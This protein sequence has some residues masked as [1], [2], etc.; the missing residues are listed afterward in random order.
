MWRWLVWSAA[1][2]LLG[3]FASSALVAFDL[4]P[5]VVSTYR[6]VGG[7]GGQGGLVVAGDHLY[8][9]DGTNGLQVLDIRDPANLKRIG[10]HATINAALAVKV[11]G[12]RAYVATG[13]G[14]LLMFDVS[15]PAEPRLIGSH[16]AKSFTADVAVVGGHA[17]LADAYA[18][19]E[20]VDVSDPAHPVLVSNYGEKLS[21]GLWAYGNA[22]AVA[23]SGSTAW[24]MLSSSGFLG[25]DIQDPANPMQIT[26][27]PSP[28]F[29]DPY[30]AGT[31]ANIAITDTA[32]CYVGNFG[33]AIS[34]RKTGKAVRSQGSQ[35][36]SSAFGV[37]IAAD[38]AY[39]VG[40]GGGLYIVELGKA[41][42]PR[43]VGS[44]RIPVKP[45]DLAVAKGHA[46]VLGVEDGLTVIDV[47]PPANP[48]QR[49]SEIRGPGPGYFQDGTAFG[50]HAYTVSDAALHVFDIQDRTNPIIVGTNSSG[51]GSVV[52]VSG[53]YAYVLS[54]SAGLSILDIREPTRPQLVGTNIS[55]GG[56]AVAASGNYA[57]VFTN[58][59]LT[60]FDASDP[61]HPTQVGAY[62]LNIP[63]FFV[64]FHLVVDGGFAY[65]STFNDGFHII[66]VRDPTSPRLAGSLPDSGP[67]AVAGGY[68]YLGSYPGLKVI[69]VRDP[70]LPRIAGV[71]DYSGEPVSLA[72]HERYVYILGG[73]LRVVDVSIPSA[74]RRVGGN[75]KFNFRPFARHRVWADGESVVASQGF[76]GV[77][78]YDAFRPLEVSAVPTPDQTKV[79]L[80][81]NG[82][83]GVPFR[84]QRSPDLRSWDN[85]SNVILGDSPATLTDTGPLSGPT[86]FYR[87]VHP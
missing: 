5:Q 51:G 25:I 34:D 11:A 18:G 69:D 62:V 64:V 15:D 30:Y 6:G 9:A 57:Y 37:T 83:R 71:Y 32:F 79:G 21:P 44:F 54:S 45:T 60:V 63:H 58:A 42:S 19:L 10:G 3:L 82:P 80:T 77:T 68:A 49:S 1:F 35:I 65:V 20:V 43:L 23:V 61:T 24:L 70:T 27:L 52:A 16:A 55:G 56:H 81:V 22:S 28:H 85:L 66:D 86:G 17:Y 33:W 47:T 84:V 29:G 39:V 12:G 26:P 46:Y 59:S 87:A 7:Q 40:I 13:K 67:L 41:T 75:P 48:Q 50:N 76:D 53:S 36:D 31:F 4:D 73:G 78:I 8:V 74:P 72:V 38:F 14:G 2:V